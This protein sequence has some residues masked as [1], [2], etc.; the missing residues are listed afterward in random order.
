MQKEDVHVGQIFDSKLLRR[1]FRFVKPYNK[2]FYLIIFLTLLL[3]VAGPLRPWLVQH[4]VDVYLVEGDRKGLLHMTLL[5]LGVLVLEFGV[6]YSH[7]YLSGWLGQSVIRDIRIALYRKILSL[8]L[9]YFDRTPIGRLVTRTIS[10]VETLSDVFTNGMAAL[11]GDL[12][13]VLFILG[14]MFYMDWRLALVSLSML[15]LLIL[16]TY[17]FKEKIKV[18]FNQV[19]NAVSN[20]NTYVQEH[21]S[22]MNITQLFAAEEHEYKKFQKINKDHRDANLQSV[23]YYSIYFPAAEIISSMGIGLL[24]WYGSGQLLKGNV[25]VGDLIAFVMYIQMFFRPIRTIAD[26]FNTLQLGI[27]STHRIMRVLNTQETIPDAGHLS[28]SHMEGHIEF[29]HVWFAYK[30]INYVLKDIHLEVPAGKTVALV[31]ETGA[32]K[33]SIINLVSRLYEYD[34]GSIRIDGHN[35]R[36]YALPY[37]RSKVGI[38]LQDVFLFSDTIYNNISL[39]DPKITA[40]DIERA[41]K[42]VGAWDF[43]QALP[44]GLDYDV[45]ERGNTLS[46]GQRQLL[47][48]IRAMVYDPAVLILDE[49]TSSVDSETEELIQGAIKKMMTGRTSIV[50]AHRLSTIQ[51]VHQIL[52]LDKGEI[53]ERGTHEELLRKGGLYANLQ[54]KQYALAE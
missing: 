11:A 27:V 17:I 15:P 25:N 10:D 26:R 42:L 47:S 13:K 12:L 30:D 16:S 44:G 54:Q 48:F 28:P 18:A 37:L 4:T 7:T 35:I 53:K 43:I 8:R 36:D 19:R 6:Q 14:F 33:S 29:D 41:A 38:V 46:V 34:K 49:A 23:L 31:G 45:K 24:I 2:V 40:K 5:M 50:I 20:L 32:G 51:H 39:G 1:L 22:G 9:S 52:V 3:G 21:I